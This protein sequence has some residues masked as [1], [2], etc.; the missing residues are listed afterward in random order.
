MKRLLTA[1]VL[2]FFL[3]LSF[4]PAQAQQDDSRVG[5]GLMVGEPTG[6]SFKY[7]TSGTKAFDAGLAWSVG[8]YDAVNIHVDHLWHNANV[9]EEVDEGLLSVYLG[10][11]ARM[12]FAD[13]FPNDGDNEVLI[14]ARV[15][16][17]I[18]YTFE[19]NPLE[20]F[21]ELAPV[22]NLIPDTDFDVNGGLGLRVYL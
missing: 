17:G 12:I 8:Q 18:N 3:A 7:W 4:S 22:V 16:V 2:L 6:L 10:V 13:D 20:L 5:V 15:P 9:F 14:G 1:T 21:L 19:N 11:G